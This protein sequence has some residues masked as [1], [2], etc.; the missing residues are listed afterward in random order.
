MAAD[1]PTIRGIAVRTVVAPMTR[2]L[3]TASGTIPG[4]PLVLI[5]VLTAARAGQSLDEMKAGIKLDAY[6]DWAQ[7]E[8]WLALN[9]EGMYERIALHRRGN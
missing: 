8:A 7:Y 1:I 2:T 9:I 3:R 4:A 6:E 5:D